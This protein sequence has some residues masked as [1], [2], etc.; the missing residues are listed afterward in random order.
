MKTEWVSLITKLSLLKGDKQNKTLLRRR[1][2]ADEAV[3]NF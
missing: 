2:R 1:G 3:C